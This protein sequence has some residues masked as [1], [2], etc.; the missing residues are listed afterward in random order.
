MAKTD[1]GLCNCQPIGAFQGFGAKV[2]K[3]VL[4]FSTVLLLACAT[5]TGCAGLQPSPMYRLDNG[6][7]E[8]PDQ[9]EGAAVLMAPVM[10]ADYLQRDALLQRLPDGSLSEDGQHA[11]WAGRL[12]DDV[13]QLV[14]RQLAWR[15]KTQNLELSPASKG[16]TPDVQVE[17]E[18]T[19]LDSGPE[20][21]AVLEAQW[22]L[23]DKKGRRQSS[24]LVRLQE[25]HQ[26]S[27]A[28][29]VQ[30]QS[31][32]LQRMS[33]LMVSAI[34]PMLAAQEQAKRNLV[35]A[36]PAKPEAAAPAVP[37]ARP[38]RAEMEVFRF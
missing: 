4:R 14:L 33:E 36:P 10:L 28:D 18:I 38:I 13:D 6:T 23:L 17:V 1:S 20:H 19:R 37:A 12:Q 30:A 27:T 15:L 8:V 22:R 5:L 2:D 3:R 31:R 29:Q 21:P 7:L 26:G 16:F 24:R 9:A 32:L 11:R 25:L 35:K 34:E